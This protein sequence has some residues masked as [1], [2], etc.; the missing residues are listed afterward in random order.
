MPRELPILRDS[1]RISH[2][3]GLI[4]LDF[5]GKTISNAEVYMIART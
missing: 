1:R 3:D 4:R 5:V 2:N